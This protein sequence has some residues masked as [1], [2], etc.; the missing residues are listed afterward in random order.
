[1]EKLQ[2]SF[3]KMRTI[4]FRVLL[5]LLAVIY[6][7][8]AQILNTDKIGKPVDSTHFF[9]GGFELG[10]NLNQQKTFLVAVDTKV[11]LSYWHLN[12]VLILTGNFALFR[13]GS[14]NLINSAFSHL[15][16]RMRIHKIFQP[17]F[18]SQIQLDN[19]RGMKQRV[20]AGGNLRFELHGKP[21]IAFHS[22]LGVMYEWETWDYSGVDAP[23]IPSNAQTIQNHFLKLN[24]YF[25]YRHKINNWADIQTVI[26]FQ[27]RPDRYFIFP[28]L[29]GDAQLT[30]KFN[31]HLGF[32]VA[33][34]IFYDAFPPVPIQRLF[35]SVTNKFIV[36]F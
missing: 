14:T 20:L 27:S 32:S 30:F 23:L 35:F 5:L 15:R 28:R 8:N 24:L 29:S 11:D 34:N 13:T 17:E 22:G 21:E 26:Y 36:S 6:S 4:V 16:Y 25:S 7:V 18:F 1:M 9:A 33:G 31:K 3:R 12:N 19:I 2:D 10:V